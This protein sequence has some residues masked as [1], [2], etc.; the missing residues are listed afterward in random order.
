MRQ[1]RYCLTAQILDAKNFHSFSNETFHFKPCCIKGSGNCARIASY[2][3]SQTTHENVLRH[4]TFPAQHWVGCILQN[5]IFCKQDL[6]I[7]EGISCCWSDCFE[8]IDLAEDFY[9]KSSYSSVSHPIAL[10]TVT[11]GEV[12]K[13]I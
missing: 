13:E 2:L 3:L 9:S 7:L 1:S 6:A 12:D 10:M 11:A 4:M 8:T 5:D